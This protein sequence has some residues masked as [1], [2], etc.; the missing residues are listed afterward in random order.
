MSLSSSGFARLH[1]ST[2]IREALERMKNINYDVILCDYSLGESTDGQQFL[3]YLRTHDLI[4][5]N[6]VFIMITAEQSYA[7]V[8]AASECAPD[9][10]LLKPFTAAQFNARL[11]RLIE[12]QAYLSSIDKA[13][14]R[15]DWAGMIAECDKL[16]PDKNKF[17]FDL[18]KIKGVALVRDQ[19]YAEAEALYREIIGIRPL[20]WALL[21]LARTLAAVD[22]IDEALEL[23]HE[24]VGEMPNFMAAYDFLGKL[25]HESGDKHKALDV[26]LK[27][28]EVAP[29]TM[30]RLREVSSIAMAVGKADIAE[31]VMKEMIAKHKHS[32]VK[33]PNDYAILS[34]ALAKQ[35]KTEEAFAALNEGKKIYG[36]MN[37]NTLF[38]LTESMIHFAARDNQAA[39]AALDRVLKSDS[40]AN[41]SPDM[42]VFAAEN[43]FAL[44]HEF[45]ATQLLRQVVQNHT[46]D[47][48]ARSKVHDAYMSFGKTDDEAT[49]LIESSSKEMISLNNEGVR[50]AQAGQLS[51]AIALLSEAAERLPN[52][53]QVVGNA[54]LIIALD[55]TR[56][57]K[58]ASKLRQCLN[59]RNALYKKSPKNPKIE[60]IDNL[61]NQLKST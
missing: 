57:G 49:E 10:Y 23:S 13:A 1:A 44:G 53:L 7:K 46:G 52:N 50:K 41:L 58:D 45:E 47:N 51:E 55:L 5:R 30:S 25:M 8:V 2:N 16:L 27:A 29:G 24:I 60:Q 12:R 42:L 34:K 56:N 32:P 31:Q 20:G 6:T 38:T 37:D 18:C 14:D 4:A 3:E 36:D 28:R 54:A 33:H 21:G 35:N 48:T 15:K 39:Q 19:R 40:L 9:D 43:S 22:R 17:Y 11:E 59:Y 61:L 26:L